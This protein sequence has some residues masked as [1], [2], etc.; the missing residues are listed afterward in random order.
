M[1]KRELRAR[2]I[3][4]DVYTQAV[5]I[6]EGVNGLLDPATSQLLVPPGTLGSPTTADADHDR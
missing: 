3:A 1:F 5:S 6:E 4:G 2:D